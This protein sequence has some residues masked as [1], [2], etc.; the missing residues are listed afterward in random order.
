MDRKEIRKW[1]ELYVRYVLKFAI[2]LGLV[3]V[4]R[5]ILLVDQRG[6]YTSYFSH[7]RIVELYHE[8]LAITNSLTL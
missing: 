7:I 2:V 1:L 5:Y 8:A 3:L 6:P 4:S